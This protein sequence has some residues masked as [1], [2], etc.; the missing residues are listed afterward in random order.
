MAQ[1][2]LVTMADDLDGTEETAK[3]KVVTVRFAVE[4][5]AYEIDLREKNK[6]K[7]DELLAPYVSKARAAGHTVTTAGGG[8]RSHTTHVPAPRNRASRER[9]ARIRKWAHDQGIKMGDRGRI[10]RDV[11][12]KYDAAHPF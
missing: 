8:R 10:P 11:E 9:G 2:V 3:E 5:D 4:K 12:Q 1:K 6:K 7:F